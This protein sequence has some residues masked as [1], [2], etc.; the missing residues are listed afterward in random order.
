MS[1]VNIIMYNMTI[2][3]IDKSDKSD[4]GDDAPLFDESKDACNDIDLSETDDDEI[5]VKQ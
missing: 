3:S 5:I 1:Y 2:P 4:N